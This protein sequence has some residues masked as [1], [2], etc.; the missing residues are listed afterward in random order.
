MTIQV[1]AIEQ[2]LPC[3]TVYCTCMIVFVVQFSVFLTIQ[4]PFS[5]A[6]WLFYQRNFEIYL[7]LEP[8]YL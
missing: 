2:R 1:K 8:T 5:D 3:G 7:N 6:D 4:V